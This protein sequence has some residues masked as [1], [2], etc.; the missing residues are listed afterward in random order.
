LKNVFN[1]ECD[2]HNTC[3]R[4]VVVIEKYNGEHAGIIAD[5]L[6]GKQQI[7][8]KSLETNYESIAG[9]AATTIMGDGSVATILDVDVICDLKKIK[10]KNK[11]K[12]R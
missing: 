8:I 5:D 4:I 3:P 1:L 7:V 12:V 9:I 6:Q 2:D 10:T 11:E